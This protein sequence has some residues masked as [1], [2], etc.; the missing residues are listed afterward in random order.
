MM[1]KAGT[2]KPEFIVQ[3]KETLKQ[4]EAQLKKEHDEAQFSVCWGLIIVAVNASDFLHFSQYQRRSPKILKFRIL[5]SS[6][7]AV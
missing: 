4:L 3:E 2:F 7:T 1:E 5:R 6:T